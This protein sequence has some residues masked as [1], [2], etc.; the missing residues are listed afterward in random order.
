M[1]KGAIWINQ[2]PQA[3]D[4]EYIVAAV[5]L[6]KKPRVIIPVADLRRK[7]VFREV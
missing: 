6:K 2:T 7:E 4:D 1:V 5:N 3:T